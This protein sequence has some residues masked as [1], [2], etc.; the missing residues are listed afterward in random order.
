MSRS[1]GAEPPRVSIVEVAPRDGL[2]NESVLLSTHDKVALIARLVDA[3]ARRIEAASF[4]DPRR[5]PQMAD[6]EAVLSAIPRGVASLIGLVLNERGLHRALAAGVDEVN[7]VLPVTDT[8][9]TRNQGQTVD[10]SLASAERITRRAQAAEVRTTVTLAVAF[11]CPFEGLVPTARLDDIVGRVVDAGPDELALADT[12]GVGLPHQVDEL[13]GLVADRAPALPLRWHFHN[14]RNTGY[15]NAHAALRA[16][17]EARAPVALDASVGGVG[18]CPFAPGASGNIATEEIAY[19]LDRSGA[20][21]GLDVP[22]LM[23][24]GSDLLERL[25][26]PGSSS[27]LR[28]ALFPRDLSA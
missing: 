23:S 21:V 14:T 22:A 20:A 4:V 8:F 11:G 19:Q 5:V 25:G 9:A 10:D 6:A 13:A 7:V 28:A 2:Q 17:A 24:I 12:I 1:T 18:G 16:A 27:F 26:R 15:A 3:G